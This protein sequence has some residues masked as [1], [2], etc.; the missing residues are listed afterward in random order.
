MSENGKVTPANEPE[1]KNFVVNYT[2][3]SQRIIEKGFFCEI[4]K[5]P[6][7]ANLTF[8]MADCAG[9][10]I[11]MIVK[12]CIELGFKLGILLGNTENE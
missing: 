3:G 2:D 5:G 4:T 8:I 11:E 10:D 6:E 7:T 9:S 1:V 12:G